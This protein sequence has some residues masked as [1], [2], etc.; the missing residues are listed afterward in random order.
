[1][2]MPSTFE[3]LSL[4]IMRLDE[5]IQAHNEVL[6]G[7]LERLKALEGRAGIALG[8][9]QSTQLLEKLEKLPGPIVVVSLKPG[10][11]DADLKSCG[12][13]VVAEDKDGAA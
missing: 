11:L 6:R 12:P 3:L 4:N 2:Q 13:I 1:M 10:E 5:N 7:I 9:P 8:K